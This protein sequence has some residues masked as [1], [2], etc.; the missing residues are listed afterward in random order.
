[1]CNVLTGKD[2]YIYKYWVGKKVVNSVVSCLMKKFKAMGYFL[3]PTFRKQFISTDSCAV[4][5]RTKLLSVILS[6]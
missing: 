4:K 5:I 2:S 1:M 3:G 6:V